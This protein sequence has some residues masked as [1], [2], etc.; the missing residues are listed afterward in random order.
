MSNDKTHPAR[1]VYILPNLIT[2]AA[3]FS[4]FYA[5]VAAIN[6]RFEI[7]AIAV[8]VSMVLDGMDGRVARWTNTQSE[9]GAQ[10]DSLADV[11]SFG[12]A[13]AIL[14]YQWSLVHMK[15]FSLAWGKV[16]WMAA[17]IYAACTALRLARFNVQIGEVDKR[18]FIGLPSPAAAAVVVSMV[19]FLSDWQI[20]GGDAQLVSLLITISAS[21]KDFDYRSKVPYIAIL[22]VIVAFAVAAIDPPTVLFAAFL[23]YAVSGPVYCLL[24]RAGYVKEVPTIMPMKEDDET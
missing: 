12:L 17:F 11:I 18:Y 23:L 4:G 16:G 19:W 24:R 20:N 1:G 15:D 21:F 9:F 6:D 2:T 10:Y 22:L 7:A 3:L 13:P 14:V 5:I 8:L